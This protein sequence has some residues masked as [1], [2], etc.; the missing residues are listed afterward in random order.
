MH[1][2]GEE[3]ETKLANEIAYAITK[4]ETS[5]FANA[6]NINVSDISS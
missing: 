3:N 4:N 1:K 5:I 6:T 2:K